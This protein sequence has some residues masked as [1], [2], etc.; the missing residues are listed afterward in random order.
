MYENLQKILYAETE[1]EAFDLSIPALWR[2][3]NAEGS[4]IRKLWKNRI[5]IDVE[6]SFHQY[7]HS[8]PRCD[9][10]QGGEGRLMTIK[11]IFKRILAWLLR[12]P[13]GQVRW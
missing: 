11:E 5:P 13:G 7:P 4:S 2:L 1:N 8:K 3:R 10:W 6:A 9:S 12:H